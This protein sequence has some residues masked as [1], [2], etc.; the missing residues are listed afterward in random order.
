MFSAEQVAG[1]NPSSIGLGGGPQ[2]SP[3]F[4][5][6]GPEPGS[7]GP[8]PLAMGPPQREM[9]SFYQYRT[10]GAGMME[11]PRVRKLKIC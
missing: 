4:P 6:G 1:F 11:S 5:E 3:M 2:P 8:A 9:A 10:R 7:E